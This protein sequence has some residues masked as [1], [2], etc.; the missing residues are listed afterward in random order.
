MKKILC[1]AVSI[2]YAGSVFAACGGEEKKHCYYYQ[3]GKLVSQSACTIVQCANA[4]G[5]MEVWKWQNGN[6][7]DVTVESEK[8]LVNGK[9]GVFF[10]KDGMS[11]YVIEKSNG[12]ALCHSEVVN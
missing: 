8:A 5:G 2:G 12:E 3:D 6:T 4:F 9:Q 7:V 10:E 11:C 1:V